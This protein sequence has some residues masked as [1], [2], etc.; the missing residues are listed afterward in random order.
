[1][2]VVPTD[3]QGVIVANY[4]VAQVAKGTG[5]DGTERSLVAIKI[6][7]R[8]KN[9]ED[10][11]EVNVVFEPTDIADFVRHLGAAAMTALDEATT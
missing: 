9:V 2:S 1:M 8:V 4:Y 3:A 5:Y 6:K 10:E 7:G 11:V